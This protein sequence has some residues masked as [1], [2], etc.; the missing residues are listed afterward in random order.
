M[1]A[2]N[3]QANI[4]S[5]LNPSNNVTLSMDRCVHLL[6]YSKFASDIIILGFRVFNKDYCI[7]FVNCQCL[8]RI[9]GMYLL[10][11]M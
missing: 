8:V 2:F 11:S 1:A 10:I 5:R 6:I 3:A 4:K 9:F 7:P